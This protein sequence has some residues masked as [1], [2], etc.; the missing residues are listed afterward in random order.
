MI[1]LM[2]LLHLH[3]GNNNIHLRFENI[4]DPECF[5]SSELG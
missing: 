4:Y 1:F 3:F 5:V 2:L